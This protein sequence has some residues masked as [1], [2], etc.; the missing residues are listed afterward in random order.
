VIPTQTDESG[1]FN[2][3][4]NIFD[5]LHAVVGYRTE[6]WIADGVTGP[7]GF[8]IGL[9][10]PIVS[11][12]INEVVTDS[13]YN[14]DA[15]YT[16]DNRNITEPMGRPSAVAVCGHS[17]DTAADVAPIPAATCLTEWWIGN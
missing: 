2:V 12:W 8:A 6:M 16:D 17:D 10:A 7:F 11:T 9:G 3:W 4:W 15:T 5:G 1:S 13:A 14:P